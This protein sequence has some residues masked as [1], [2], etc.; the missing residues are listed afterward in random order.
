MRIQAAPGADDLKDRRNSQKSSGDSVQI[1]GSPK[2]DEKSSLVFT[3]GVTTVTTVQ[4][5]V[6][7]TRL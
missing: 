1:N 2:P 6:R 3:D 7:E 4:P 5:S